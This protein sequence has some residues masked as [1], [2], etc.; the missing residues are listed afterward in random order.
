MMAAARARRGLAFFTFMDKNLK[1][2][3]EIIHKLLVTKGITVGERSCTFLEIFIPQEL[4]DA[5][6]IY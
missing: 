6:K 1:D 5:C 4:F 3:L 2:E